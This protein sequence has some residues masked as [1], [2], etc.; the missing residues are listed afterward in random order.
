[1]QRAVRMLVTIAAVALI[2]ALP[3][4]TASAEQGLDFRGLGIFK[5][6]SSPASTAK[7]KSVTPKKPQSG[8]TQQTQSKPLSSGS[9]VSNAPHVAGESRKAKTSDKQHKRK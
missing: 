5:I 6:D 9:S 4:N 7:S 1:M 3:N 2:S 8:L